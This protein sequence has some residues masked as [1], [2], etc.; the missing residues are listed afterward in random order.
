[1]T[2]QL[3]FCIIYIEIERTRKSQQLAS[4]STSELYA[5]ILSSLNKTDLPCQLEAKITNSG[6]NAKTIRFA[7]IEP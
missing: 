2:W 1:M 5:V 7:V 4:I 6:R 3:K